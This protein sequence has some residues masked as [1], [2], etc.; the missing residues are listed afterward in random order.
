MFNKNEIYSIE[1]FLVFLKIVK[2]N[3]LEIIKRVPIT[4]S[5]KSLLCI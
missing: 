2:N 4:I 3:T 1:L 5:P